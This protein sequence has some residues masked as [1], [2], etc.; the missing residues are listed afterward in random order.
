MDLADRIGRRRDDSF[1]EPMANESVSP[2]ER[3]IRVALTESLMVE[4]KASFTSAAG[5]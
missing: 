4:R 5:A 3:L 1:A 2:D